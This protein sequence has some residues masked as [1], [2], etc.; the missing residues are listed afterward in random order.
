MT[1]ITAKD[2]TKRARG[3][4]M[5]LERAIAPDPYDLLPKVS[6][7]FISPFSSLVL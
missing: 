4:A 6:S 1:A 5:L 2:E 3:I 7:F